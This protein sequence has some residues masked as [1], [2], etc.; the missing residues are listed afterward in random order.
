VA[1]RQPR[2]K[3]IELEYC[4]DRLLGSKLA[5]A[6]QLLVPDKVRVT[7]RRANGMA[8]FGKTEQV[9]RHKITRPLRQRG[10]Y[11]PRNKQCQSR[12]TTGRVDWN[13]STTLG[14]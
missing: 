12:A 10:G 3:T 2:Q 8:C 1:D 6:Y 7:G 13:P 9:E 14:Q 4:F 5:Q 11:S